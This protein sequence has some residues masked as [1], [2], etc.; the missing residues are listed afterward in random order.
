MKRSSPSFPEMFARKLNGPACGS[1]TAPAPAR[2]A[3]A[4]QPGARQAAS[5]MTR[6]QIAECD[7]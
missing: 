3:R 7:A 2:R 6:F 1:F 5:A 4:R